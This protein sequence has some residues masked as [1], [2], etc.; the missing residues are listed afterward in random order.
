[1]QKISVFSLLL[2]FFSLGLVSNTL[3]QAEPGTVVMEYTLG[4][5]LDSVPKLNLLKMGRFQKLW[6]YDRQDENL[7]MNGIRI[8]HVVKLSDDFGF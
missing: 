6:R 5:H 8:A 7:V 3:A 4:M 1:M 2:C